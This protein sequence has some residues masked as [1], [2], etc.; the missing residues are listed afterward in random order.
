MSLTLLIA[1]V[2]PP[3]TT[4]VPPEPD[5][6]AQ[7]PLPFLCEEPSLGQHSRQRPA[8]IP[9]QV[10]VLTRAIVEVLVGMRPPATLASRTLASVVSR[11]VPV[12]GLHGMRTAS[13]HYQVREDIVE[14][15]VR[16]ADERRSAALALRLE[17]RG[18]RWWLTALEY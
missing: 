16:L 18:R 11:L 17:L 15:S 9:E 12:V 7:E 14:A 6:P 1:D 10:T 2:R 4:W 5:D 3:A 8:P 13:V